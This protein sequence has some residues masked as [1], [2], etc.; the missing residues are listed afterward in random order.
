MKKFVSCLAVILCFFSFAFVGCGKV[1][2][3]N[4][5]DVTSGENDYLVC[6]FSPDGNVGK[7]A[8]MIADELDSHLIQIVPAS[9]Y[10]TNARELK[11]RITD[12]RNND[13]RPA[14]KNAISSIGSYKYVFIGYPVWQSDLPNIIR[15]FADTY[16]GSLSNTIVVPFCVYENDVG[17]SLDYSVREI[18]DSTLKQGLAVKL[19]EIDSEQ[20]TAEIAD[21]IANTI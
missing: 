2:D 1:D 16:K 4:P 21:W 11:D 12:E 6:Y 7:V 20:L 8:K 5:K 9:A 17:S 19:S 3:V 18:F 15:T 10:P 13:A 14:I